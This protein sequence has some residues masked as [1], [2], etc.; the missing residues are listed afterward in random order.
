MI[1]LL[2]RWLWTSKTVRLALLYAS[3]SL[4]VTALPPIAQAQPILILCS[5]DLVPQNFSCGTAA[6]SNGGASTAVGDA[7]IGFGTGTSVFGTNAAAL[8]DFGTAIGCVR[9]RAFG[10]R[11]DG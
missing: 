8:F 1:R 5:D 6:S 2:A 7:S 11:L 3:V 10:E 9:G 4:G